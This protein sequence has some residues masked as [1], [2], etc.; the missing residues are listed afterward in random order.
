MTASITTSLPVRVVSVRRTAARI[1]VATL[2]LTYA[3]TIPVG[4]PLKIYEVVLGALFVIALVEERIVVAPG[5]R[6]YLE[7]LLAFLA[8][9]TVVLVFRLVVRLE[10]FSTFGFTSRAGPVG[11]GILKLGYWGLAIFAFVVVATEAYE[12][13]RA[14]GRIWCSAAVLASLYG[15]SLTVTSALGLPSPL[16]PGMDGAARIWLGGREVLRGATM[17]E[18]NF[19]SLYLLTSIALAIWLR[20]MRTAWFLGATVFIT[21]STANVAGLVLM[22]GW[23]AAVRFRR[24]G[25]VRAKIRLVATIVAAA[26]SLL[27]GLIAT[28]YLGTIFIAKLSG[29]QFASG[30]DRLDLSVAGARM[31]AAHPLVGVGLAQYGF[32]YRP[33]QL[34][35]VFDV[36][37]DVKPIAT[38]SW[39]ELTAETGLLGTSLILVFGARVWRSTR[40]DRRLA[41]RT[42]LAALALGLFSFPAPTV[43][44]LWAF[45]GLVVGTQLREKRLATG[46]RHERQ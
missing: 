3:L 2:P 6:P 32:H 36:N 34:T 21:F 42:G 22:L 4:F 35:D 8:F 24:S 28:G 16:L 25:D 23:I 31:T 15:W 11:D 40:G 44:F 14:L 29:A 38:D 43:T 45:C 17:Q 26:A 30:L 7:P 9:T 20:R 37:R 1:V 41:L 13:P 33:F 5:L 18:G 39:I 10:T 46:D 12:S 19:F 27:G